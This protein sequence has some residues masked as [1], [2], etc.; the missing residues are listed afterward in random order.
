MYNDNCNCKVNA[1][2]CVPTPTESM[3]SIII[4]LHEILCECESVARGIEGQLF[5]PSPADPGKEMNVL[6]MH[7][8]L[9]DIRRTAKETAE[10]LYSIN[11]RIEG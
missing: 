8:A 5:G 6:S 3:K 10:I 4:G 7:A 11:Q 2:T 1:D 9:V